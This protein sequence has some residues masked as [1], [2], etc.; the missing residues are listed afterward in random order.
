MLRHRE[1]QQQEFHLHLRQRLEA[2]RL[3]QR[4]AFVQRDD[5]SSIRTRHALSDHCR[6]VR[7]SRWEWWSVSSVR[8]A[9]FVS[10][11]VVLAGCGDYE[12][13]LS[14]GYIL[15]RISSGT[16]VVV[17]PSHHVVV[18]PTVDRCQVVG[19]FF[20][21]RVSGDD[22]QHS[23]FIVNMRSGN[24]Q[25]GLNEIEWRR[26]LATSGVTDYRLVRPTRYVT[27]T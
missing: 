25:R 8:V 13:P 1:L 22:G 17:D 6:L 21:G 23:Y 12:I 7:L 26:Q 20:I 27:F 4:S 24:V 11:A 15:G 10:V 9:M 14:H 19:D 5:E 3:V 2:S 16:F 18:G